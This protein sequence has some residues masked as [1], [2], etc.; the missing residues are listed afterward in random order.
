MTAFV[1]PVETPSIIP[2][3][4]YSCSVS[5]VGSS[6]REFA[7]YRLELQPGFKILGGGERGVRDLSEISM[8]GGGWKQREG[9]NFLRLQEWEGS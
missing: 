4:S 1:S 7:E 2:N 6:K 8:G 3:R 5:L 9:Q